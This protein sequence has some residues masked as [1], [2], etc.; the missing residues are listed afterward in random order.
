MDRSILP[1]F[2]LQKLISEK[3]AI[4]FIRRLKKKVS[5]SSVK[6][7]GVTMFEKSARAEN[8]RRGRCDCNVNSHKAGDGRIGVR[9]GEGGVS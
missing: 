7:W 6:V 9:R 4:L 2:T 8:G 5:K 1:S 3:N